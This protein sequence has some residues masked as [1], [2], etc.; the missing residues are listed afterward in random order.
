MLL[1]GKF[2]QGDFKQYYALAK[3][4][5]T[6]VLLNDKENQVIHAYKGQY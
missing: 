2:F 1:K 6:S 4:F 5:K 3:F